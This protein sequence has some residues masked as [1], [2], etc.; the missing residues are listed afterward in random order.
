MRAVKQISPWQFALFRIALGLYLVQHF[1]RLWPYGPELFSRAGVLPDVTANPTH[2]LFPNLLA[3]WDTPTGVHIFLAAMLLLAVALTL[4]VAR[5]TTC[6]LLW[7]GWACLFN[8][9]MLIS[10][11]SIPFV[12]LTL[13]FLVLIPPGEPLALTGRRRDDWAF[14]AMIFITA[15]VLMAAGYTFSGLDKLLQ[16]PSWLNGT[17]LEHVAHN[18]LARAGWPRDLFLALP[19]WV[20]RA[21]TWSALALEIL[22][23]PLCLWR[24]TRPWAWVL[25][26]GMHLGILVLVDF[27]DLTVAMLLFHAFTFDPDWLPSRR[28]LGRCVVF[29]DGHCALCHGSVKF[30]MAEDRA[31]VLTYAPLQGTTFSTVKKRATIDDD[32]DSIVYVRGLNDE[33]VPGAVF[34]LSE[35]AL[36]ILRDV[37]GFW[38]VASWAR[39][40]PR[41]LRDPVYDFIARHRYRWFGQ[42]DTCRVPTPRERDQCLP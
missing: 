33:D 2:A 42:Y 5:R 31:A 10:N 3:A 38:R 34:V 20:L 26:I 18:P 7:Y 41:R 8:R 14:P 4:G 1:V 16:S 29:F 36:Q 24:R 13:L 35:A 30:L 21:A 15:W 9:N 27:A 11:P 19:T 39:I 12:G 32:L 22:F 17:A 6:L 25:M 28:G 23:A 40:I 37:G